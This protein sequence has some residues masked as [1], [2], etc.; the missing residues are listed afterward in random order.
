MQAIPLLAASRYGPYW[1]LT[2]DLATGPLVVLVGG[3]SI[4]SGRPGG[5]AWAAV[6]AAPAGGRHRSAQAA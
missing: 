2:F 4:L 3:L 6:P 1:V 5:S